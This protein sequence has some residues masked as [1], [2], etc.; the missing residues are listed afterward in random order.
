MDSMYEDLL[1]EMNKELNK[2]SQTSDSLN[3]YQ[4]EKRFREITDKYNQQLFQASQGKVPK[5]KNEHHKVQTSF[6][7]MVV[8]KK[9]IR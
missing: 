3:G 1:L 2:F 8:K 7:E 6:G 9:D 4:Y 5:S